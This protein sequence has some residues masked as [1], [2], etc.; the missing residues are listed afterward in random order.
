M[1]VFDTVA[2]LIMVSIISGS[3]GHTHAEI[4]AK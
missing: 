2:T 3:G 4:M 1:M